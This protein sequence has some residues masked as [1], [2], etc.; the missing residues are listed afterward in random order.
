M[1]RGASGLSGAAAGAQLE[2]ELA[3]LHDALARLRSSIATAHIGD[4][5]V[6]E[7]LLLGLLAGGHVLLEGVP[8]LGKTTLVRALA[9]S[10]ELSF[11]RVQF[12]PDLMPGDILGMRVLEQDEQGQRRFV[13]QPGPVFANVVL[14]DEINR[15]TPRTQSALLEAM[16]ERQVTLYG[17]MHPLDDPFFLIATQNPIE[18][19]GT[20]PLPE[21]Q[22]DRF[23]LQV[24]MAPPGLEELEAI[25]LATA[26]RPEPRIEPVLGLRE[27]RRLREL[28]RSV[29]VGSEVV[30]AVAL[31]VQA[32]HPANPKAPEAV[33]RHVRYGASPRG[34][35]AVLWTAQA[36]ALVHGRAHVSMQDVEAVCVPT[37]RH[38]LILSYEG[39]ASGA[40]TDD[41]V[42]QALSAAR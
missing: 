21:A 40:R 5:R 35:Q 34:G 10:L 26:M 14:A 23:L 39:E 18:M 1:D 7:E 36:R 42:R 27:V 9:D 37:L 17:E 4:E 13:F 2:R 22:L 33:R 19:E 31:L 20:Y 41:L 16:Q 8:G 25:L 30:H 29:P 24:E 32:T 38:R 11:R 6:V 3:G 28:A 12:T 15:A